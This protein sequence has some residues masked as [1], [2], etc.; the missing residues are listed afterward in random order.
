MQLFIA[1]GYVETQSFGSSFEDARYVYP[2][3][4]PDE[5][6]QFVEYASQHKDDV[7]RWEIVTETASD[8]KA[9]Y[10]RH[11]AWVED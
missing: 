1:V 9:T 4:D 10:N 2:F 6:M 3:T 11:R 7:D 5:A 8:A